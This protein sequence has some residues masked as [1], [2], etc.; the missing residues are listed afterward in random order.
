MSRFL[1]VPGSF[2]DLSFC[3]LKS[4]YP[5]LTDYGFYF[6]V[7][8]KL[9]N[10]SSIFSRLGG[11]TRLAKSLK[12]ADIIK[13]LS[14]VKNDKVIFGI[15]AFSYDGNIRQEELN[16]KVEEIAYHLK[17]KL[18]ERSINS[19]FIKPKS[20]VLN[21]GQLEKNKILEK[22]IELLIFIHKDGT[23]EFG[24]TIL[25]QDV[26]NFAQIEREKPYSN[27]YMGM[28]PVKLARIMVNM[29]QPLE[30]NKFLWDP[31]CGSGNIVL[32][33]L[34]LGNN[35]FA[36]DIE[37]EAIKGTLQNIEWLKKEYS[38][39]SKYIVK[40]LNVK[41]SYDINKY[42]DIIKNVG[43]IVAE[44]YMGKP[45][46]K[47]LAKDELSHLQSEYINLVTSFFH[48]IEGYLADRTKVVLV[49][50]E[51]KTINGFQKLDLEKYLQKWLKPDEC[52]NK[53]LQWS[54]SNSII[55]RRISKFTF[56]KESK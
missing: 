17:S 14:S 32:Q 50:P 47:L 42:S 16:K 35:I 39:S 10:A 7:D 33:S 44:P 30:K 9:E 11:F 46:H 22:G 3:E 23:I 13:R 41:N 34:L 37:N 15:S 25:F 49:V 1:F 2:Q 26:R 31:F 40:R 8:D 45:Q 56:T 6:V 53:Y 55:R 38:V 36:S 4:Y 27:A 52:N 18:K 43:A 48:R 12:E 29:V 19:R 21:V 54:R 5:S 20:L 51:Y 28:L 24:E